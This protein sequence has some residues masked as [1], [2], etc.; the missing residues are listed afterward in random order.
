MR[1]PWHHRPIH[2][3]SVVAVINAIQA[4]TIGENPIHLCCVVNAILIAIITP[5]VAIKLNL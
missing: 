3:V 4:S 2:L 5:Y 1:K